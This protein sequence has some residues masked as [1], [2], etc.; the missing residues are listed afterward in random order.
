[1]AN[2]LNHAKNL[3]YKV[4]FQDT[5]EKKMAH[6]I[7]VI[8]PARYASTRFPGK[9]LIDIDGLTLLQRTYNRVQL[10]PLVTRIIIAT[11]DQR[12][13]DHAQSFG[14][15]CV[16]TSPDCLTG[17]DRV[18]EVVVQQPELQEK[19]MLINVQCDEPCF[20]P[21]IIDKIASTLSSS[22][23]IATAVTPLI[24]EKDLVNPSIVKCVKRLDG[25]ALYFSR[26]PIPRVQKQAHFSYFR[27]IGIY[28]FWPKFLLK[29][30][31]LPATPLQLTEDL[32][33]LKALEHGFSIATV[34]VESC[35]P[36]VNTREDI[37]K[38][39]AWNQSFCS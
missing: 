9:P 4:Y 1:L 24:N 7:V 33:M 10:S 13:F 27:H 26:Q 8:I 38:V 17:T 32:E 22:D 12:I 16:M 37:S 3:V 36:E 39:I 5:Y 14:G 28:A 2:I 21:T 19:T 34:E 18:A 30:M 20:D 35:A 6:S 29:F 11:D 25:R 15:E 31:T 23:D